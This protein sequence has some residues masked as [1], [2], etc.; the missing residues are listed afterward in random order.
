M[1]RVLARMRMR[2]APSR[3][4]SRDFLVGRFEVDTVGTCRALVGFWTGCF[5]C[6]LEMLHRW[7]VLVLLY[8][9]AL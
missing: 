4:S 6:V 7:T 1:R 9:K 2:G 3:P 5:L 8:V